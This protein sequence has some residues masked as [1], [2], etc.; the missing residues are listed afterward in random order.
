MTER[1]DGKMS[2]GKNGGAMEYIANDYCACGH[3]LYDHTH[4]YDDQEWCD[5]CECD[6]FSP[7][8][9]EATPDQPTTK[10]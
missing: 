4:L 5:F 8:Q 7:Q 3:H 9:R 10:P 6:E 2:E 1:E